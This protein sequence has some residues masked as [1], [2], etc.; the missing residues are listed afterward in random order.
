MLVSKTDVKVVNLFCKEG[1]QSF[2]INNLCL[3]C[4]SILHV[5]KLKALLNNYFFVK[6]VQNLDV[7]ILLIFHEILDCCKIFL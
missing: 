7:R 2:F 6:P 5:P 3:L 4:Y 1:V